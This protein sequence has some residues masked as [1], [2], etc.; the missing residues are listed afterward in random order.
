[1]T[2]LEK[3]PTT[4]FYPKNN[5]DGSAHG[6]LKVQIGPLRPIITTN[7]EKVSKPKL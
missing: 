3:E 5:V 6:P 1:M 7:D 2:V 4:L